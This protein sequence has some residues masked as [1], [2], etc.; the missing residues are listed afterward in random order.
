MAGKNSEA[1]WRDYQFL[2]KE[3][4]KFLAKDLE[5]FFE[6]MGQR[7]V[8]QVSIEQAPEDGFKQSPEGQ[9]LLKEIQIDSQSISQELQVILS[10]GKR[11][12]Q[13]SEAYTI[14]N[15]T[16]VSQMNWNR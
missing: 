15:T 3:M 2:T 10:K 5:L 14:A 11:Q 6:L 9:S 16:A 1:L 7:E 4:K 8:L 12:H 13:V